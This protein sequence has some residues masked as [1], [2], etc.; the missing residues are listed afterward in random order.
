[1]SRFYD[2]GIWLTVL[3]LFVGPG[4]VLVKWYENECIEKAKAGAGKTSRGSGK[5]IS[6]LKP[7]I[8]RHRYP[9]IGTP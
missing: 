5:A 3:L 7:V 4:W 9:N 6:N 1:M 8:D 2:R